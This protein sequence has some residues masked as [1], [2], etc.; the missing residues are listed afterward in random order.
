MQAAALFMRALDTRGSV[1][2]PYVFNGFRED[3]V[4]RIV[5]ALS[6]FVPDKVDAMYN[7]WL[8]SRYGLKLFAHR[9]TWE[10]GELSADTVDLLIEEI[11]GY[12]GPTTG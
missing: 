9:A 12:Y 5:N 8:I 3:E 1:Y 11:V 4:E 2:S 6:E 10:I 7:N